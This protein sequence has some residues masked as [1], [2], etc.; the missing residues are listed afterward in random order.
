MFENIIKKIEFETF[1]T[2]RDLN[3]EE[4]WSVTISIMKKVEKEKYLPGSSKKEIVLKILIHLIDKKVDDCYE[5]ETLLY[6]TNNHLPHIIDVLV[7]VSKNHISLKKLS[8]R[9]CCF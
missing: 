1:G 7:F 2:I 3:V 9:F 4:L 5:K 6:I 8:G